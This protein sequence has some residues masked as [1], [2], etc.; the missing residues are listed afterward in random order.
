M[1]T[2][3]QH[4]RTASRLSRLADNGNL[5]WPTLFGDVDDLGCF[6]SRD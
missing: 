6:V 4:E 2:A 3:G 1:A 5:P